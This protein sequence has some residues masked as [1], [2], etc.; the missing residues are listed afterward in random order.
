MPISVVANKVMLHRK[1]LLSGIVIVG[2]SVLPLLFMEVVLRWFPVST[3]TAAMAVNDQNPVLRYLPNQQFVFSKGWQ[4][5]IVNAGRI[6]NYGFV[7]DLDYVPHAVDGPVVVIGDSYVEAMMVPYEETVQG[8]LSGLLKTKRLVYSL[9]I[10][11]AELADYLAFAQFAWNEF[12]PSA[13]VFV[14]VGNDFDESLSKYSTGPG[15]HFSSVSNASEF[16]MVRTDYRPSFW[17][18]M[19]RQSVLVRYLWKTIGVGHLSEIISRKFG[20]ARRYVGNTEASVSE[21]RLAD[22]QMAID[23][24]FRELPQRTGVPKSRILFVVDGVRPDVYSGTGEA[25][26]SK[27]YFYIMR[28]YFLAEAS[29]LGYETIDMHPRFAARHQMDGARFEFRIDGHWNGLGHQVAAEAIASSRVLQ[30]AISR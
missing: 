10:S 11:G 9:G 1:V 26:E 23:Q 20:N 30:S 4:F 28:Q 21:E 29:K 15:Y 12:H 2:A 24:F 27:T 18:S 3:S 16:R 14:V 17:K 7:N 25:V 22:S 5:E 19:I 6:N 13:M 8:R